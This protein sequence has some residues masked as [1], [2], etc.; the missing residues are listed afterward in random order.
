MSEPPSIKSF[1]DTDLYKLS[2][3]AAVFKHFK[4]VN[5]KYRYTNRTALMV[6]NNEAIAWVKQQILDLGQLNYTKDE[7]DYLRNALPMM[8]SEFLDSLAYFKLRPSEQISYFN[9]ESAL[10][11]FYLEI[12][13][14]WYETIP[15]EIHILALVSEAYFK[16]VDT[17]WDYEG[18]HELAR[19]KTRVLLANGCTFSEFGT[20]RRRSFETQDMVVASICEE[21][22]TNENGS[23]FLGTSNVLL[24]KKYGV[25]PI[26]TVAHE[27]FMGVASITESYRDANK[28][29]MDIWI[30]T[31]GPDNCGLALTDTFGTDA[32][33]E[34]FKKPY[35]DHYTGVR[36][37]SGDPELYT[38]TIAKHFKSLGYPAFS[39]TV[40][41]SDSLDIEKCLK[42]KRCAEA[43]GMKVSFG[44]GTFFTN[45]FK[46]NLG[47]REKSQPLNIVI[48]LAEA[49]GNPS[50]K[51]SD[52]QG[53]NM[54]DKDVVR[55]VKEEL[56]YSEK[57]WSEGDE[58]RR[59]N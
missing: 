15:Y 30:D 22:R 48:K 33:L 10:E 59:W 46:K 50:V 58:A 24:A 53:K 26:G 52:N 2:M 11:D 20:R 5:V 43:N 21:A 44:I 28:V 36:Q 4:D 18:Q 1:L 39:K 13:G 9:D 54:G 57:E 3:Q 47:A 23:L 12:T 8:P 29:A 45:D 38:Q 49:A 7:I 25:A 41:F 6:L 16:F 32:Y 27:F 56:G 40:C 42:Y 19:E 14:T 31:F 35:T 17:E 55:K 51:I 37:D 34:V